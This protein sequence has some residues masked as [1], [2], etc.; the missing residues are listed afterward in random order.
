[1]RSADG[2]QLLRQRRLVR[3]GQWKGFGAFFFLGTELPGKTLGIVGAGRIG[4][5]VARKA[6]AFG[7]Q[8]AYWSRTPKPDFGARALDLDSLL[9]ESD[10]VVLTVSLSAETRHLIG[11]RELGLMKKSAFLVNIARG[12]VVDEAALARAL[13]DGKIAG[14]GLDVYEKEPEIHPDLLRCPNA[15]LA[16]HIGSATIETRRRMSLLAARNLIEGL[17]GRVPPLALNPGAR[18]SGAQSS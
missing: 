13:V 9:R 12:P 2:V 7:M 18:V 6:P 1:V 4:Q 16:P 10:V 14:A 15:V 5:A 11:A 17:K 3:A 8:A